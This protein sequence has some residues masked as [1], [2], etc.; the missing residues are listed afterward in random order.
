MLLTTE[1][2]NE[3]RIAMA[4][5]NATSE[6]LLYVCMILFITKR[7]RTTPTPANSATQ[8]IYIMLSLPN[9]KNMKQEVPEDQ[10]IR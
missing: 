10:I 6:G 9:I 4:R 2:R 1:K 7:P 3:M 8:S 5:A